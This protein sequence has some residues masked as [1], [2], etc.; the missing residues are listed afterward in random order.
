MTT[1][2]HLLVADLY[3]NAVYMVRHASE[4]LEEEDERVSAR[5]VRRVELAAID[6]HYPRSVAYEEGRMFVTEMSPNRVVEIVFDL[7][8]GGY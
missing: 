4:E 2:G 5:G 1:S 3:G 8:Q 6:L 7:D